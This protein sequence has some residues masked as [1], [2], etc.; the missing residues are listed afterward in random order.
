MSQQTAAAD[1]SGITDMTDITD[2]WLSWVSCAFCNAALLC[3]VLAKG[4]EG[5]IFHSLLLQPWFEQQYAALL[6]AKSCCCCCCCFNELRCQNS[7]CRQCCSYLLL[8]PLPLMLKM[9]VS[10]LLLLLLLLHIII[11]EPGPAHQTDTC[12]CP[13]SQLQTTKDI[14]RDM[15]SK[16]IVATEIRGRDNH[17]A[18]QAAEALLQ[19]AGIAAAAAAQSPAPILTPINHGTAAT[20]TMPGQNTSSGHH[21]LPKGKIHMCSCHRAATFE[22]RCTYATI[23]RL[24]LSWPAPRGFRRGRCIQEGSGVL[25]AN[26]ETAL[27]S[28]CMANVQDMRNTVQCSV[29]SAT[30]ALPASSLSWNQ[31]GHILF[32]KHYCTIISKQLS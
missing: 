23:H 18:K 17:S 27:L 19:S 14:C 3:H 1:T 4:T 2:T 26:F 20:E 22:S 16:E 21:W 12:I 31:S 11:A 10:F 25:A 15:A 30:A 29:L 32:S 24:N 9:A 5:L 28:L 6:S 13:P 7:A 8:L